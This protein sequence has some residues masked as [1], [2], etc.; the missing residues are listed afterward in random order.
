MQPPPTPK[1]TRK[2]QK[3][4]DERLD[5]AFELLQQSASKKEEDECQIFGNLVAKNCK[6]I[7]LRCAPQYK[8]KLW[9]RYLE[10]IAL[11]ATAIQVL[12]PS[13]TFLCLSS[14]RNNR[15]KRYKHMQPCIDL[16]QQSGHQPPRPIV[17]QIIIQHFRFHLLH[18]QRTA[19]I[20]TNF[21]NYFIFFFIYTLHTHTSCCRTCA[22]QKTG[23][24]FFDCIF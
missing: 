2:R 12:L 16:D 5:K 4:Q 19:K 6:D 24:C 8:R 1:T 11:C 9:E 13:K 14:R 18:Q 21:T 20:I 10:P 23:T 17:L 22:S 3:I 15:T 7:P